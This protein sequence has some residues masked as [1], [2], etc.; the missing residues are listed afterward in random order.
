MPVKFIRFLHLA[1]LEIIIARV[2]NPG[3]VGIDLFAP[4]HL[5]VAHG[6]V[7]AKADIVAPAVRVVGRHVG[8]DFIAFQFIGRPSCGHA[9]IDR[10]DEGGE[11]DVVLVVEV[12]R[13][14]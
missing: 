7:A 13:G 10:H 12:A 8:V 6:A 1:I 4:V 11:T 5:V 14:D 2:T 9:A 3:V